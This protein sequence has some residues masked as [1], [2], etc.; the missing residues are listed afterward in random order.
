VILRQHYLS[1]EDLDVTMSSL[2]WGPILF[3]GEEFL[4]AASEKSP[5]EHVRAAALFY[6]ANLLAFKADF[7]TIRKGTP[8]SKTPQSPAEKALQEKDRRTM[9]RLK[10]ID[11]TKARK[12]A[13]RLAKRVLAEY[14]K[15]APPRRAAEPGTPFM[16][17]RIGKPKPRDPR[18]LVRWNTAGKIPPEPKIPTWAERAEA[19]LFDLTQLNVGQPAPP[20]EGSDALEKPFRL[21][22]C[23]DKV[24]VL[25]FSANWCTP[26]KQ[27]YPAL[28]ELQKK[29]KDQP[30]E[31]VTV[32]A[33]SERKTVRQAMDRG[34]ITWRAVWD[35]DHGP[36][37]TKWNVHRFPTL[38]VVDPHGI[39]RARDPQTETLAELVTGLLTQNEGQR[40][41]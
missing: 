17:K 33:D 2:R 19:L 27:T 34:D 31:V 35:G 20:I 22:D 1:H 21:S 38:Y 37:A 4:K 24:V 30:V 23:K 3:R 32:M 11:E 29:F 18:L 6:W 12:E 36:I 40:K 10:S 25:M 9:E 8:P 26:C 15:T 5:H 28:R 16:P 7:V 13:E 41:R 14:A 39:I